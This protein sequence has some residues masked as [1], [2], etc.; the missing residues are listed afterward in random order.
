[1]N[2]SRKRD[3]VN[4]IKELT[5][6]GVPCEIGGWAND[7]A[8]LTA[9]FAGFYQAPWETVERVVKGD[10]A[11]V[12]EDVTLTNMIWKGDGT[13]IPDKVREYFHIPNR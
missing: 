9:D 7:Y 10:G 2:Y 8:T 3:L 12:V 11:F 6:E 5:F 13:P 1:M 4:T